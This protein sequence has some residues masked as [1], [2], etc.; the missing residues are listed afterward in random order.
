MFTEGVAQR[1]LNS[2]KMLFTGAEICEVCSSSEVL[3][4]GA[5]PENDAGELGV[6]GNASVMID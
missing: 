4:H 3:V 2:Q 1:K 5:E 6:D